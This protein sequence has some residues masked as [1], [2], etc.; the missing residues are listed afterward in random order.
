MESLFELWGKRNPEW[1]KRYQTTIMDVFTDYGKGVNQ[2]QDIRGKIFGAGYEIYIIAFFIGLYYDQTK[3]L[4]DDKAKRKVLGQAIMYWGN[5]ENRM[6]RNSYSKIREYIFAALIAKTNIDLIALDKGEVSARSVVDELITKMEQYANFGF[7]YIEEQLE[8]DPNYFF[9]E[10]A[11]LRVFTSFLTNENTADDSIDEPDSLD[12][13]LDSLNDEHSSLGDSHNEEELETED[14]IDEETMRAEAEKPWNQDDID[15]LTMFFEHGM[16]IAVIAERLGK[17]LYSVQYQLSQLDKIKMPLN[18]TVKNTEQGGTVINKSG[19]VIYTD[20]APLK[21]FNDKIYRFNMKSM[22]MTVKDVK[23]VDGEWV[24]GSKMLVAYSDSELY[25]KLS[26][27]NFIDDIED[28]VEG[29]ERET[30]KIKVKG[31]WYD[32]YGDRL[33]S[34]DR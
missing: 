26:H 14:I 32:Y 24:K 27:S 23:R 13:E 30:S 8:N 15:R 21:V 4:V 31:I 1:E 2:Y 11:F 28:F 22:C 19:Q 6:G 3:P 5:V 18:V 17:S 7:D 16:E 34:K 25:P 9:K 29:D 12:D 10:S 20:K 33:G